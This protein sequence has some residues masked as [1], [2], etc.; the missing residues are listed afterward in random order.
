MEEWYYKYSI[1]NI[2]N[3]NTLVVF[4][5]LNWNYSWWQTPCVTTIVIK[6]I[7]LTLNN[8][9]T[10]LCACCENVNVLCIITGR[11]HCRLIDMPNTVYLHVYVS[12]KS[13]YS[14]ILELTSR[15]QSW[16]HPLVITIYFSK[17]QNMFKTNTFAIGR[18]T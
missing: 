1:L 8:K 18:V 6:S 15:L 4:F 7:P 10:Y 16:L 17:N 5:R 12:T 3:L 11:G 13:I 14:H 2:Y 9:L